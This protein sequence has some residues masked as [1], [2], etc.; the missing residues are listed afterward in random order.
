MRKLL[1][2]AMSIWSRIWSFQHLHFHF[3]LKLWAY[4]LFPT[5]RS[6]FVV[7]FD[8]ICKWEWQV[9]IAWELRSL[10]KVW[11]SLFPIDV[12]ECLPIHSDPSVEPSQKSRYVVCHVMSHDSFSWLHVLHHTYIVPYGNIQIWEHVISSQQIA[13][14][15]ICSWLVK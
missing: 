4:T 1:T 5:Q 15:A 12:E 6:T 7:P 9:E 11:S 8:E 14:S 13:K 3:K 2:L 10:N